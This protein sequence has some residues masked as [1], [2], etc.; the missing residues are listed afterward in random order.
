MV[1]FPD[2][3]WVAL[4]NP[5]EV[6]TSS[7]WC[8]GV[9]ASGCCGTMEAVRVS[10]RK[11]HLWVLCVSHGGIEAGNKGEGPLG[12]PGLKGPL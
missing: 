4:R 12:W 3:Q 10:G 7:W 2:V 8:Q 6:S 11:S 9:L 1:I 5:R